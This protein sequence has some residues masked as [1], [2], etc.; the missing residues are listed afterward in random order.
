MEITHFANSVPKVD[1]H[2]KRA[3]VLVEPSAAMI[4]S[5]SF[6]SFYF[7]S[8]RQHFDENFSKRLHFTEFVAAVRNIQ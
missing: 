2:L 1:I 6:F 8:D 4:F 3:L 5:F 7:I